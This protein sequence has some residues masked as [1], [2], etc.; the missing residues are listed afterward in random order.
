MKFK[1]SPEFLVV[2]ILFISI[3]FVSS[4]GSSKYIPY[5]ESNSSLDMFPY[6][7]GVETMTGNGSYDATSFSS[8]GSGTPSP[9]TTSPPTTSATSGDSS[10]QHKKLELLLSSLDETTPKKNSE[11]FDTLSSYSAKYGSEGNIDVISQ[12]SSSPNCIGKSSGLSNSSGGICFTPQINQ[13]L[14]TRGNN[15]SGQ[16]SQIGA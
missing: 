11:S 5:E 8:A 13:L 3:M 7:E 15:A 2:V 16:P 6:R 1:L 4:Y 14:Q 12:L 9:P 10:K